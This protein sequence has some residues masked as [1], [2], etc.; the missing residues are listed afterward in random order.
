MINK[1]KSYME[2][3][4]RYTMSDKER[5]EIALSL[6]TIE[7]TAEPIKEEEEESVK[8]AEHKKLVTLDQLRDRFNHLAVAKNK[9]KELIDLLQEYG[10]QKLF[11][12]P[13]ESYET[14]FQRLEAL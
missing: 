12:L 4:T 14:V 11:E 13:P 5:A 7:K 3:L 8:P 10:V 1:F 6:L 2:E 9:T